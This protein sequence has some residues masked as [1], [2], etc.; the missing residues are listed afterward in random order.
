VSIGAA[1]ATVYAHFAMSELIPPGSQT[2]RPLT[3]QH[4]RKAK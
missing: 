2:E 3:T 4:T 1:R